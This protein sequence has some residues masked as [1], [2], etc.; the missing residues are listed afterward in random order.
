MVP[1]GKGTAS[2]E[3]NLINRRHLLLPKNQASGTEGS[4]PL[5]SSGESGA[6]LT[7]G[8]NAIDGRRG[9]LAS[10]GWDRINRLAQSFHTARACEVG[11]AR[12]G[13]DMHG[14]ES[15]AAALY[16]RLTALT[17]P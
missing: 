9:C 1:P 16:V 14:I 11:Q 2:F 17:T 6:N 4:N 13:L 10:I 8:A 15:H 12:R 7:F 5:S 3:A